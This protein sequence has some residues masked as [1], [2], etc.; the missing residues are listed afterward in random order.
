MMTISH[1]RGQKRK[2]LRRQLWEGA[3]QAAQ[4]ASSKT[5]L[6]LV[7]PA[8]LS[9]VHAS[10]SREPLAGEPVTATRLLYGLEQFFH[11]NPPLWP[12]V[13]RGLQLV[14]P[15]GVD[16]RQSNHYGGGM[17]RDIRRLV[18]KRV[19]ELRELRG[20]SQEELAAIAAVDQ[21]Y[22]SQIEN[23]RRTPS[24]EV[25]DRL[26]RALGVTA[27]DLIQEPQETVDGEDLGLWFALLE[28]MTPEKRKF[29]KELI[30]Q[31]LKGEGEWT[32]SRVSRE[33]GEPST[34]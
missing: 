34:G 23:A 30:M 24:I 11:G 31:F 32:A 16:N 14:K 19:R 10:T 1:I 33:S 4:R 7:D 2:D 8:Q 27:A 12:I 25:L 17:S 6:P 21:S 29:V 9:G 3:Q 22:L 20:W 26:A 5:C 15:N 13:I 18:G 28:R